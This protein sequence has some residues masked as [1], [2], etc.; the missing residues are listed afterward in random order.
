LG[1]QESGTTNQNK[2]LLAIPGKLRPDALKLKLDTGRKRIGQ[3]G[4]HS[5]D[6]IAV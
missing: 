5:S 3:E 2:R 1:F 6:N 4:G